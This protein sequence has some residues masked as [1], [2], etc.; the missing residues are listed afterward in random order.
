MK[1]HGKPA[2][3]KLTLQW[4]SLN[5]SKTDLNPSSVADENVSDELQQKAIQ[6]DCLMRIIKEK[7]TNSGSYC[8]EIQY[9]PLCPNEWSMEKASR[10]FQVSQYLIRKARDL[11]TEYGILTLPSQKRGHL[12]NLMWK[13]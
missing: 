10:Y 7:V 2:N 13:K 4:K 9:L 1:L 3:E 12:F 11:T 6:F 5:I 8:E